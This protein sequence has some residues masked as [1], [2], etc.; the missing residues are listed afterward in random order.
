LPPLVAPVV[1]AALVA[2]PALVVPVLLVEV[3]SGP[4]LVVPV[5]LVEVVSGPPPELPEPQARPD[6]AVEVPGTTQE[7]FSQPQLSPSGSEDASAQS[8]WQVPSI[9][10]P[11][12]VEPPE[13]PALPEPPDELAAVVALL[14]DPDPA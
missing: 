13:V 12:P 8:G 9:S 1:L 6:S 2:P 4:P 10:T 3:V 11:L 5:V 7:S 14:P